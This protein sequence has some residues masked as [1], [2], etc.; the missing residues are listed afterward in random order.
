ML[1]LPIQ[2]IST[3]ELSK[4]INSHANPATIDPD[5]VD[6]D[7]L[8]IDDQKYLVRHLLEKAITEIESQDRHL[9][10]WEADTLTGAIGAAM[11]GMYKLSMTKIE[12]SQLK[13]NAVVHP[14]I[15][16]SNTEQYTCS[17]IR[18]SLS[19]LH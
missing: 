15:W 16:F 10:K 7:Q 18:E 4:P 19:H 6:F 9:T 13:R 1:D 8:T 11:C 3:H 12:L 2:F 5:L 14:Q 17:Q